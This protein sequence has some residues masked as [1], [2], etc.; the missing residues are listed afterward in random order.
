MS[1]AELIA[2]ADDAGAAAV[3]EVCELA[4]AQAPHAQEG[5]SY[6]V[7]ALRHL[8][9]P[10]I[11]IGTNAKGFSLFPFSPA[12]VTAVAADLPG[13]TL[14]KG[15]IGFSGTRPIPRPVLTRIVRLR[16]AEIEPSPR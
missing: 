16:L 1:F 7:A 15:S 10:L 13:F 5:P 3:R 6:G 12:V 2:T 11:G 14:T 9:R 8:G 4:L